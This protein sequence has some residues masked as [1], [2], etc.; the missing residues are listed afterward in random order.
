MRAV[1]MCVGNAEAIIRP[2]LPRTAP[3]RY[4]A[5]RSSCT[6][7]LYPVKGSLAQRTAYTSDGRRHRKFFLAPNWR[8]MVRESATT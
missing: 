7:L 6:P 8:G 1:H 3:V 5:L 2:A 4:A